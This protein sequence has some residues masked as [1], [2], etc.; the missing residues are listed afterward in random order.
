MSTKHL[1]QDSGNILDAC[2]PRDTE[3]SRLDRQTFYQ[4]LDP[5]LQQIRLI[6]IKPADTYEDPVECEIITS[7]LKCEPV[8]TAISYVWGDPDV[9]ESIVIDGNVTQITTN[10]AAALRQIRTSILPKARSNGRRVIP[11]FIWAD[12]LCIN[13]VDLEERNHQVQLMASV[14]KSASL[15]VAWLGRSTPELLLAI[16]WINI[17]GSGLKRNGLHLDWAGHLDALWNLDDPNDVWY[18]IGVMFR[19]PFWSRIWVLQE[20]AFARKLWF[21][22]GHAIC[23]YEH[24]ENV[25]A[26]HRK[27][28]AGTVGTP[29]FLGSDIASWLYV[30]KL[31]QTNDLKLLD[32]LHK[33]RYS[34]QRT[35]SLADIAFTLKFQ[36]SDPRDKLYAL[37]GL[38]SI[39]ISPD[40]SI[41]PRELYSEFARSSIRL[42]HLDFVLQY[43]GL[44]IRTSNNL[45]NLPSYVPDLFGMSIAHELSVFSSSPGIYQANTALPVSSPMHTTRVLEDKV[46]SCIGCKIGTI[47]ATILEPT[48]EN[49]ILDLYALCRTILDGPYNTS[50]PPLQAIFRVLFQDMLLPT[51]QDASNLDK[52]IFRFLWMV[53]FG[54]LDDDELTA[55]N[56]VEIRWEM[57]G[58]Q[59]TTYLELC[60]FLAAQFSIRIEDIPQIPSSSASIFQILV[61]QAGEPGDIWLQRNRISDIFSENQRRLF[62]SSDGYLGLGP[63][64]TLP[65]DV[66]C[67]LKDCNVPV[68][69]RPTENGYYQHVSLCCV[70][71]I[72]DGEAAEMVKE[73]KL[74]ME[75]FLIV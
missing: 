74:N 14:Y 4:P 56:S 59:S 15:V 9:T 48:K 34:A 68:I 65:G 67:V 27:V 49:G 12:A 60:N 1:S 33:I 29:K 28:R 18:S 45:F 19:N 2:S 24:M 42:K 66:L 35:M 52:S 32:L 25:A 37:I 75:T 11:K 54:S 69:L 39:D 20:L 6:R 5:E 16:R 70:A 63:R 26:I 46:L 38:L 43:S 13:Q 21:L 36:A 41:S 71:G 23:S 44:G 3:N 40:Y 72:M 73:G 58:I 62:H 31:C 7:S 10:L 50:L 61:G 55:S 53:L 47:N 30:D 17:L 22:C 57:L 8:Y 64:N 51:Y